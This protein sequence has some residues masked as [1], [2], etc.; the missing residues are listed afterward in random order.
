MGSCVCLASLAA[1]AVPIEG[2]WNTGV[3]SA[4]VPQAVGFTEVHYSATLPDGANPHYQFR[5]VAKPGSYVTPPSDSAWIGPSLTEN[6][7]ALV[8]DPVGTYTYKLF[9][10]LDGLDPASAVIT[11]DWAS[12]NWSSIWLNGQQTTYSLPKEGF[13]TLTAFNLFDGI[14][15]TSGQPIRLDSSLN[16]LEF[17]VLNATG[18]GNPS[19]LL[20]SGL[21][22]EATGIP[23]GGSLLLMAGGAF[24]AVIGLSHRWGGRSKSQKSA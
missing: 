1:S 20:V 12:D 10:S 19:A 15:N 3:D 22:G 21:S 7:G 9:F 13:R 23:D 11:G 5:T 24:A 16:T 8:D 14:L 2:L 18:S 4:G 6:E 17:R